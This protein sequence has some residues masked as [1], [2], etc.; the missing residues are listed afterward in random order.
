MDTMLGRMLVGIK[1]LIAVVLCAVSLLAACDP[2]QNF[3]NPNEPLFA[4]DYAKRQPEFDGEIKTLT[5]NIKFGQ[6]VETA[7]AELTEV[8]ELQEADI[9]LLQEMDEQGVDEI[10]RALQYNYVY[11]PASIHTRHDKNFGNAILSP[12]PL[13]RDHKILLPHADPY[14]GTRRIAVSAD[15]TVGDD[16]HRVYSVHAA[17]M[18]VGLGA[19]LDQ[20]RTIALDA[21]STTRP[22]IIAGDFN[23]ADPA[24]KDQTI[25]LLGEFGFAWA[26]PAALDSG[27]G[28]NTRFTLD[29]IFARDVGLGDS[30]TFAGDSGSDHQ[31]VWADLGLPQPP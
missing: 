25:E 16:V 1:H 17:T 23:T 31:P 26:S 12:W 8:E 19:R 24:S 6:E 13:A 9:I 14:T 5:W 29:Y 18:T 20:A 30:G 21:R 3:E 4:A 2:I 28:Y 11:F 27:S 22:T 15:V 7:I 10:A